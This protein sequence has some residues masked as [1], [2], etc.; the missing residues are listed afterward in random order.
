MK[1]EPKSSK[2]I[3]NNLKK[4]IPKLAFPYEAGFPVSVSFLIQ[5]FVRNKNELNF[6][7]L[8]EKPIGKV[9]KK[10]K[11]KIQKSDIDENIEKGLI[12]IIKVHLIALEVPSGIEKEVDDIEQIFQRL[13]RQGNTIR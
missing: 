13:N 6:D 12:N 10:V 5:R 9:I 4:T 1:K 8:C 3:T 11:D 2:L 7:K